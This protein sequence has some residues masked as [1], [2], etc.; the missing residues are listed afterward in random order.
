MAFE[1]N[2]AINTA[3]SST[4]V[5]IRHAWMKDSTSKE[6]SSRRNFIKFALARLHAVSSINMYSE[7][8]LLA[9]IRPSGKHV[10][11]SLIVVSYCT[12]GSAHDHAAYA[13][14]SHRSRARTV[15]AGLPSVR[16]R[17]V[18]SASSPTAA[19]NSLLMRT[20]LLEF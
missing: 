11:H 15:L 3:I 14:S 12:P 6:P 4:T 20:E 5:Q 8:G 18:Q 19:R 9:L 13:T 17:S 10:C 16:R 1:G 2:C 7:H